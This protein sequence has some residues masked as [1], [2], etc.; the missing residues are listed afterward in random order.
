MTDDNCDSGDVSVTI[1]IIINEDEEEIF[2]LIDQYMIYN[3]ELDTS[4]E[5][6]KY[7]CN[8]SDEIDTSTSQIV[9]TSCSSEEQIAI[10]ENHPELLLLS[11][12]DKEGDICNNDMYNI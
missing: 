7:Y 3:N 6:I 10:L 4:I 2:F 11:I 8:S 1:N 9:I 5:L 12:S